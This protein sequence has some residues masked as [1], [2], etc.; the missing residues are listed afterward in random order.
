MGNISIIQNNNLI[1]SIFFR[2]T[3]SRKLSTYQINQENLLTR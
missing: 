3:T 1:I 2:I